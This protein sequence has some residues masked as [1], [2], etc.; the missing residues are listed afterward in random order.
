MSTRSFSISER[1]LVLLIGM[2]L[3]ASGVIF[4]L[5]RERPSVA[6]RSAPIVLEGIRVVVPTFRD[7]RKIDLNTARLDELVA[8]PGIG[9]TLAGRIIAY[10]ETH[11]R[12]ETVEELI[13]VHGIG[14]Q[15]LDALRELVTVERDTTQPPG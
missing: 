1:G 14:E 2:A 5:S 12:F 4:F 13:E 10:R 7:E 9:E 11:G 8:L 3:L 15:V 6:L